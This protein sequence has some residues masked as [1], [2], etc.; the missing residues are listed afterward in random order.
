MKNVS[1]LM[2]L[3]AV[4]A[5]AVA[6]ACKKKDDDK[7]NKKKN[8]GKVQP[9]GKAKPKDKPKK[10]ET[11]KTTE[12][13]VKAHLAA[14]G[15]RDMK[16]ILADYAA[17]AMLITPMGT[18]KGH[19]QLKGMF[20]KFFAEFAKP[21][22]KFKMG[23]T[24]FKDD[25]GF[26]TWSG[27]TAD[28]T[29][30]MA[31]DTFVVKDGKIVA[32]TFAGMIKP[33]AKKD[34]PKAKAPVEEKKVAKKEEKRPAP[35]KGSTAAVLAS[36]L[37]AFGKGDMK[38]ILADYADTAAL[39]SPMGELAG[40]EK[41]TGLFKQLFAE[42]GKKGTK[43]KMLHTTVE[44]EIAFIV[45]SAETPDNSYELATDTFIIRGGK[46]VNQ[47]FAAKATPKKK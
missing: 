28:N 36:H 15:K 34:A 4:V 21:G 44:G 16:A 45:W 30:E 31:T 2:G 22:M 5:L 43:F 7:K 27:E 9:K 10:P 19:E 32:Q 42:F 26:I 24:L 14:F 1:Y 13:V 23:K 25:V 29:Y 38:A 35:E 17:D 40:K 11:K 47:T 41:L 8:V 37:A 6:P 18:A 12:D 46:I 33:K 39:L 3:L 20:T